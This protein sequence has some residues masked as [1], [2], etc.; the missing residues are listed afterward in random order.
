MSIRTIIVFLL[1]LSAIAGCKSNQSAEN[2]SNPLAGD[3]VFEGVES[4]H[5]PGASAEIHLQNRT[6]SLIGWYQVAGITSDTTK[7]SFAF[8]AMRSGFDRNGVVT[9]GYW[10]VSDSGVK[11]AYNT[12]WPYRFTQAQALTAY[13]LVGFGECFVDTTMKSIQVYDNFS[14]YHFQLS[15]QGTR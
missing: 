7:R 5:T 15:L 9:P 12:T 1:T 8:K 14:N 4:S 2:S 3:L 10:S 11:R 13:I 6:D